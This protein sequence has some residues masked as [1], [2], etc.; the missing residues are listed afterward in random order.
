MRDIKLYRS[1]EA[2]KEFHK[3]AQGLINLSRRQTNILVYQI[4]QF[5]YASCIIFIIGVYCNVII[6]WKKNVYLQ[7]Y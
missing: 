1:L 5:P 3:I 2:Y 7:L 6:H 4:F